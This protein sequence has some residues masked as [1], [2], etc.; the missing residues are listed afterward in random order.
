MSSCQIFLVVFLCLTL[1]VFRD[2][3]VWINKTHNCEQGTCFP[4][5]GCGWGKKFFIKNMN[6]LDRYYHGKIESIG[7]ALSEE[8]C[9]QPHNSKMYIL[10]KKVRKIKKRNIV[11]LHFVTTFHK[12]AQKIETC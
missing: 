11:F 2:S 3:I 1:Q 12:F 6:S 9:L 10:R 4:N 5:N 7:Q 8:K